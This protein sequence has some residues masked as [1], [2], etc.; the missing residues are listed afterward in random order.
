MVLVINF[1]CQKSP[2]ESLHFFSFKQIEIPLK[3]QTFLFNLIKISK[4]YLVKFI[5]E[6]S[7]EKNLMSYK[8]QE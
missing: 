3:T 4:F 2:F 6:K 7:K 5:F 8:S 1:L